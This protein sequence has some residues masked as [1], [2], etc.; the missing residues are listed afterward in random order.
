VEPGR[1]AKN[2]GRRI[3]E[4]R[5]ARGWTQQ[6]LAD[7]LMVQVARVARIE[8]GENLRLDS[9]ERIARVLGI[10]PRRLLQ[11]PNSRTKRRPGRPRKRRTSRA[12]R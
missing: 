11:S 4:V 12:G 1:L 2:V 3:A 7:R 10:A 8:A 9:V 5:R 6:Q